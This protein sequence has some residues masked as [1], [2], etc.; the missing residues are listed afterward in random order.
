[1]NIKIDMNFNVDKKIFYEYF[2]INIFNT[3]RN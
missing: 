2:H 3:N 1:M